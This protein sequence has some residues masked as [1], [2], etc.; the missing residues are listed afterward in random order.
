MT[1]I[2]FL[3]ALAIIVLGPKKSIELSGTAGEWYRK[4][5]RAKDELFGQLNSELH[6]SEGPVQH[7]QP[8]TDSSH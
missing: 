2:L 8:P 4:A 6:R 7:I 1:T 3:L 5:Q